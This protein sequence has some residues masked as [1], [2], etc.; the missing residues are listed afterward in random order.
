LLCDL[1]RGL[2]LTTGHLASEP[3]QVLQPTDP[4]QANLFGYVG[5]DPVNSFDYD[6]YGHSQFIPGLIHAADVVCA[7]EGLGEAARAVAALGTRSV[8]GTA[9][10]AIYGVARATTS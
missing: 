2:T 6:P 9:A 10:C 3:D 4:A 8:V 1:E 7:G 5:G